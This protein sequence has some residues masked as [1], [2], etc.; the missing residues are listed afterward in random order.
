MRLQPGLRMARQQLPPIPN[1]TISTTLS[2]PVGFPPSD[3]A[4]TTSKL[5]QGFPKLFLQRANAAHTAY[6]RLS[7]LIKTPNVDPDIIWAAYEDFHRLLPSAPREH[8]HVHTLRHALRR[9]I[10]D[11]RNIRRQTDGRLSTAQRWARLKSPHPF[12]YRMRTILQDMRELGH[13][14]TV[15][16]YYWVLSQLAAAGHATAAE[17]VLREMMALARLP[18]AE[19][20]TLVLQACIRKLETRIPHSAVEEGAATAS[21]IARDVVE[22]M[23]EQGIEIDSKHVSLLLRVFKASLHI[24]GFELLL[25]TL[26]AFDIKRPDR[27]AK[28]FEDR[29]KAADQNGQ[30]LPLPLKVNRDILTTMMHVWGEAGE[31]GRA[32]V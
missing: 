30:P 5:A 10:P 11:W 24:E 22:A 8:E 12:E 28:E 25:R 4:P 23:G 18:T 31:I 26:F 27:M 1:R 21:R 19:I 32:H 3:N 16:D 2:I 9:C 17:A 13:T 20:Y 7:T 15:P 14:P 29:L 6:G